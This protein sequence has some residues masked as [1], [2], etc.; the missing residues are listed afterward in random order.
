MDILYNAKNYFT[1]LEKSIRFFVD[2]FKCKTYY[3]NITYEHVY[4]CSYI[5]ITEV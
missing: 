3:S 1:V 5:D 2:F 4:I